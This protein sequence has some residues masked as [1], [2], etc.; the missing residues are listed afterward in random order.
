MVGYDET[1]A[2]FDELGIAYRLYTHPPVMT[3]AEANS[4]WENI[5]GRHCKCLFLKDKTKRLWLV[6][7]PAELRVNLKDLSEKLGCQ[8]LSFAS[9]ELLV[10]HLGVL[11]G[12][13]TPLSIIND[14]QH[15]V[16]LVLDEDMLCSPMVNYHPMVNTATVSLSPAD[17]LRY[18]AHAQHEPVIAALAGDSAHD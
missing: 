14:T 7:A 4:V 17:L 13:V 12:S 3:V 16:T 18:V 10:E 1:L 5:E 15:K 2:C 9:P 11:P 8:R 6:T